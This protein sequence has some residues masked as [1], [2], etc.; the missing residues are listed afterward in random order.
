MA[1]MVGRVTLPVCLDVGGKMVEVGTVQVDMDLRA[2]RI[3]TETNRMYA[4]LDLH[5]ED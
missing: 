2:V 1:E 4:V 5:V 3:D